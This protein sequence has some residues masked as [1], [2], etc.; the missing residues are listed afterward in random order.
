MLKKVEKCTKTC[1]HYTSVFIFVSFFNSSFHMNIIYYI[2]I[3]NNIH[4]KL[5]EI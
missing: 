1:V 4:N 3:K 5:N 2:N